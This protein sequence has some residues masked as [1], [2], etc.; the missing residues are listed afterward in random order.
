MARPSRESSA[1]VSDQARQRQN[2]RDEA[3]RKK[4]ELDINKK[5]SQN[6]QN[7]SGPPGSGNSDLPTTPN[8]ADRRPRGYNQQRKYAPGTVAALR[9]AV[10]LTVPDDINIVEAAQLMAAKRADSVLVVGEDERLSGIFTAKD[11][12]FRVVAEG[13]NAR[14]TLVRDIATPNP[15][16]VTTDTQATD[17]LNTMV[18]R[19]FRHLPVCNDEGDV[20]GLLDVIKCMYEAL[21]KMDRAYQTSK[22]L[23]EALEGVEKEWSVNPSHLVSFVDSMRD[24]MS[25]PT[26]GSLIDGSAPIMVSP[27][28]NVQEIARLMR[29]NRT[30][31]SLV[32]EENG[33]RIAGIFTSKDLVLRVVAAGLNPSNCSVVRVMTPHPDTVPPETSIID[34]LK[35]MYER[36]YLN[37]P[38]VSPDSE[39]LGV[40]DVLRLCYATLEQMKTIQRK[41]QEEHGG[42]SSQVGAESDINGGPMW[43]RF[44]NGTLP[45]ELD[46]RSDTGH[47]VGPQGSYLE[48]YSNS[49][50]PEVFPNDSASVAED[51]RSAVNSRV[52]EQEAFPPGFTSP[53]YPSGMPIPA[54]M[55]TNTGS[56][57][58][59]ATAA[60]QLTSSMNK[61]PPNVPE[62]HYTFKFKSPSGKTHRFTSPKDD[63]GKLRSTLIKLTTQDGTQNVEELIEKVGIAYIDDEGDAVNLSTTEDLQHAVQTAEQLFTYRVSIQ[64]NPQA[65]DQYTKAKEKAAKEAQE[66]EQRKKEA[67]SAA[68]AAAA[69]SQPP[70]APTPKAVD[71]V[72]NIG[73]FGVP[74][75]YLLPTALGGGFAA[76]LVVVFIASR[77]A[78]N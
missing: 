69:A 57:P 6:R 48:R 27:R 37:L 70:A 46:N 25:C 62:G 76:A 68:A 30:T 34:A 26:L 66:E 13:L 32:M 16:C 14:S 39:I 35:R 19:G 23:Y 65:L 2:R 75:K 3:I 41:K 64:F 38:V 77:L 31:A 67:A 61:P 54:H 11:V 1:G 15:L 5:K 42:G 78:K 49:Q 7:R 58:Q 29:A 71:N 18:D 21:D 9:P 53:T 45:A 74:E 4:A 40:I 60:S 8:S 59:S 36:H 20:V 55:L 43:S 52:G 17:A 33:D 22:A 44:F 51:I 50:I 24:Q 12:A 56:H 28:T 47:S 10:A 63:I 73:P 72:V